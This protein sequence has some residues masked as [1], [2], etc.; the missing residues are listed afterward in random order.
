MLS[1]KSS[2]AHYAVRPNKPNLWYWSREMF[3]TGPS[4]D[5]WLMLRKTELPNGF[6][7]RSFYRQNLWLQDVTFF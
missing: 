6:S 3:I 2:F 4:K 7:G 5:R 1:D